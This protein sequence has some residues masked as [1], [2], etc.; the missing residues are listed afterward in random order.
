M[1]FAYQVGWLAVA[2]ALFAVMWRAGVKRYS[3]VGG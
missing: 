3:A 2:L 1:G